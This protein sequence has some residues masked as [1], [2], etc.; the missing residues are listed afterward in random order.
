MQFGIE[1]GWIGEM[2]DLYVLPEMR[3]Q[4]VARGLV[5]AVETFLITKGAAGYQITLTSHAKE[6]RSLQCCLDMGLIVGKSPDTLISGH[7]CEVR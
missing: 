7:E 6:V 4:G 1:F 5:A 2:G 3:S